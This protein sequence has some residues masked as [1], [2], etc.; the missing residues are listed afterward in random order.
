MATN[1]E[2]TR[3]GAAAA[4]QASSGSVMVLQLGSIVQKDMPDSTFML[5]ANY[6]EDKNTALYGIQ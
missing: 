6:Q 1:T 2:V 4:A 5:P 3:H